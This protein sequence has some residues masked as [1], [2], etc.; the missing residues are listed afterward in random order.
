MTRRARVLSYGS[1][2]LLVILGTVAAILWSGTL[3]QVLA[4][5]LIGSGLVLATALVFY[6]V[7]LSEDRERE[8]EQAHQTPKPK[9]PAVRP[10][11]RLDRMRGRPR[12]LR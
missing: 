12:R 8:R 10:R 11:R 6:E 9:R 4:L 7:G 1:S 2:G 3:G 5:A